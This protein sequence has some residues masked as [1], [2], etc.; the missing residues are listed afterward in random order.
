MS[1]NGYF[2]NTYSE[3]RAKFLAAARTAGANLIHYALPKFHGPRGQEL[4][5]DVARFGPQK[6]ES[7]LVLISALTASRVF[8]AQAV[9]SVILAINCMRHFQLR[10]G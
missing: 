4:I 3:A 9:R 5:L 2:A 10:Q 7:L 6:P 8:A 1:I